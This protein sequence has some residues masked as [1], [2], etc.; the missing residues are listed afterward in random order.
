M[1]CMHIKLSGPNTSLHICNHIHYKKLQH[2]FPKM[3]GGVKGRLEF[4]QKFIQF[5]SGILPKVQLPHIVLL[6]FS[7]AHRKVTFAWHLKLVLF[8][9]NDCSTHQMEHNQVFIFMFVLSSLSH[10]PNSLPS[11]IELAH[12]KRTIFLS[13]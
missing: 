2:N 3:R 4:F 1:K 6:R 9:P 11:P 7:F 13:S 12:K 5:G 10:C 8:I